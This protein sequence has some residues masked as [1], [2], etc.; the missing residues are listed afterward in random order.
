VTEQADAVQR[1]AQ[2][3]ELLVDERAH[4]ASV[5]AAEQILGGGTMACRNP[6]V[7]LFMRGIA[8]LRQACTLNQL[9]GHA[10]KCGDY[11]DRRRAVQRVDD[12]SSD[13]PDA[14]GRG[15]RRSAEL[16]DSHCGQALTTT[17]GRAGRMGYHPEV[18]CARST[19]G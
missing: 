11:D 7:R 1:V 18:A 10:L 16:E 19:H 8:P 5:M 2:L 14:I 9:I 15:E 13:I 17:I 4:A 3:A 6:L 12:D